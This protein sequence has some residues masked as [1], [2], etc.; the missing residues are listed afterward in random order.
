V[1][2]YF[3]GRGLGIAQDSYLM[4]DGK[5][6]VFLRPT[7][8]KNKK[9]KIKASAKNNSLLEVYINRRLQGQLRLDEEISSAEFDLG[10][11]K[12]SQVISVMLKI[13]DQEVTDPRVRFYEISVE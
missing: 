4:V 6:I 9:I 12:K 5:A 3:L 13:V 8:I 2:P 11:I 10:E 1:E 7:Q